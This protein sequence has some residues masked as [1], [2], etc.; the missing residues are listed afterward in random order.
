MD[1]RYIVTFFLIG[2][3]LVLDMALFL[4]RVRERRTVEKR[5]AS[6]RE[7]LLLTNCAEYGLSDREVEVVR[8]ILEGKTYKE[9]GGSLFISEKTVD[10]HM[11]H[12]YGKAGVRTRLAL[13]NKLYA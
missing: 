6:A 11:Q 10:S 2:L 5:K 8:L 13:L 4:K 9:V 12:I 3:L 1:Y 7:L